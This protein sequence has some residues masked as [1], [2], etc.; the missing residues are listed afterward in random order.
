M[1]FLNQPV[2]LQCLHLLFRQDL[3][4]L[5][6][7][8]FLQIID[9]SG[10]FQYIFPCDRSESGKFL[11]YILLHSFIPGASIEPYRKTVRFI[12]YLLQEHEFH[13]TL[14][15]ENGI[16][17]S[18]NKNFLLAF[19]NRTQIGECDGIF[20]LTGSIHGL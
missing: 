10:E 1:G 8:D 20:S 2:F 19:G 5:L 11:Q 12:P 3:L 17:F 7:W 6:P 18:R 15:K 14:L 9:A 16:F 13:R 4:D